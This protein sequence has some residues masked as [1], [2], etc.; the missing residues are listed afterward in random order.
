M[1]EST[2]PT[3]WFVLVLG[4][5][6]PLCYVA[7]VQSTT[8][9]SRAAHQVLPLLVCQQDIWVPNLFLLFMCSEIH[10]SKKK[11]QISHAQMYMC[12]VS[13]PAPICS[14]PSSFPLETTKNTED[15]DDTLLLIR[16]EI[17]ITCAQ[18]EERNRESHA[19]GSWGSFHY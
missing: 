12:G 7:P 2:V 9:D 1:S 17:S 4:C 5:P 15:A 14:N 11:W 6:A 10:I 13:F 18:R 8:Q 19:G 3:I 16:A